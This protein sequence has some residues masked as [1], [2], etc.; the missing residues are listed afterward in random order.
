MEILRKILF[1]SIFAFP[2]VGNSQIAFL[3]KYTGGPFDQGNGLTQLPDSSYAVT[4]TSA[5]FDNNSGQA[6]LMITDSLGNQK[7][8]KSYGGVGEDVGVRV[9]HIPGDG[10]F[11]AGYT[12]STSNGDFDFVLYKTDELGDLQWEKTYGGPDWEILHDAKLLSDG[13]LILV[14][15]TEGQLSQG[16]DMFMVRTNSVGDTLWTKTIRTPQDDVAYAVDTLSSTQFVV[17]GDLGDVGYLKGMIMGFNNDGTQEWVRFYHNNG[18]SK[19]RDVVVY[20]NHIY[21]IGGLY[22][23]SQSQFDR[24][25]AKGDLNGN[26]VNYWV[27]SYSGNSIFTAGAIRDDMGA[28]LAL[29]SQAP[30]LSPFPGGN[31]AFVLKLSTY[32]FF[33][34]HSANFSAYDEDRINQM[35]VANDGGIVLVGTVSDDHEKS[36]LGTSIMLA[37]MGPNDE[38]IEV[39]DVGND[40]VGLFQEE[41]KTI[42][43][44]PN[45]TSSSIYIPSDLEHKP[46]ELRNVQGKLV[47]SGIVTPEISMLGLDNGIYFMMI[48]DKNQILTAKI[49]K[50]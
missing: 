45:P 37:R 29:Q 27:N 1:V 11:I 12:G 25:F 3:K 30:E 8:T 49:I 19:V 36:S 32:M 13:G 26:Y 40:M 43:V 42:T 18:I 28:Y 46:Y 48:E 2:F 23:S 24:W 35:I 6:F 31:D 41:M 5:A 14:G 10:F 22:D 4:G 16:K 38:T 21:L 15:E 44:F 17:G 47:K 20:N 34:S 39:Q 50:Q 33:N 9:I 7:W